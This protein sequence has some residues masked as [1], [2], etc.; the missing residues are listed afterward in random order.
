MIPNLSFNQNSIR[1]ETDLSKALMETVN[2]FTCYSTERN[3][4]PVVTL[5]HTHYSILASNQLP[6]HPTDITCWFHYKFKKK[7]HFIICNCHISKLRFN[8][9]YQNFSTSLAWSNLYLK[10]LELNLFK[11]KVLYKKTHWNVFIFNFIHPAHLLFNKKVC[12][13][14]GNRIRR[15]IFRVEGNQRMNYR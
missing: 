9:I 5:P 3:I 11:I 4:I 14:T 1:H 8:N 6:L 13:I 7:I 12:Q 10:S 15:F 2:F